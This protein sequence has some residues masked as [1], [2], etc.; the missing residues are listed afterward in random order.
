MHD[1]DGVEVEAAHQADDD[2]AAGDDV[3][4]VLVGE[5][6]VVRP[7]GASLGRATEV[8]WAELVA[9]SDDPFDAEPLDS[10]HPLFLGYTSGTTGRPKGAVHVHAGF[11]VKVA[12]EVAYQVDLHPDETLHWVTDL[13]WIMGPWEIV[14]A[15]ALGATVLLTEGAPTVPGPDRLWATVERHRVTTLGVSPTQR[16]ASL[17]LSSKRK[18]S[19]SCRA[20]SRSVSSSSC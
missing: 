14:G 16:L 17:K 2:D 13:G 15:L 11:L 1:L 6:G 12:S 4:D 3:V 7:V 19:I 8:P 18:G 9:T 5:P 10:E 20:S